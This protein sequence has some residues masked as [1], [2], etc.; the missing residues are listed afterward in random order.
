VR[1]QRRVIEG[2]PAGLVR[3]HEGRG[4]DARLTEILGARA[5]TAYDRARRLWPLSVTTLYPAGPTP[6][7]RVRVQRWLAPR[8]SANDQQ[9]SVRRGEHL[10]DHPDLAELCG[11]YADE[12][13]AAGAEEV[14]D[15]PYTYGRR[16]FG[17]AL[18][19]VV[20]NIYRLDAAS[21]QVLPVGILGLPSRLGQHFTGPAPIRPRRDPLG[22]SPSRP[23][24]G[25]HALGL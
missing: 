5:T 20:R 19:A 13:L 6:A 9:S 24:S 16:A 3:A 23:R 11:P 18:N 2:P 7:L 22:R 25:A 14:C 8:Q 1:L 10:A 12:L 17:I 4:F 21:V 15:W